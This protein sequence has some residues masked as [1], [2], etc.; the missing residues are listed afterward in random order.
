[1]QQTAIGQE[2]TDLTL[3]G[4]ATLGAVSVID[5]LGLTIKLG[6]TQTGGD[7]AIMQSPARLDT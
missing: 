6:T 1:M 7:V 3:L 4:L 5:C 2:R